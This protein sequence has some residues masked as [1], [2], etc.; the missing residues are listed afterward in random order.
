MFGLYLSFEH[1]LVLHV[2]HSSISAL[3]M[4]SIPEDY[5]C[6]PKVVL[7]GAEDGSIFTN[8]LDFENAVKNHESP[9]VE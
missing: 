2:H 7:S 8:I 3:C 6:S 4:P 1:V 9:G 5:N